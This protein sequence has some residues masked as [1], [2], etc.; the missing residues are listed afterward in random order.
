[1]ADLEATSVPSGKYSRPSDSIAEQDLRISCHIWLQRIYGPRLTHRSPFGALNP[2]PSFVVFY[3]P[4]PTASLS[5]SAPDNHLVFYKVKGQCCFGPSLRHGAISALSSSE[6]PRHRSEGSKPTSPGGCLG[7][8]TP[9]FHDRLPQPRILRREG[10]GPEARRP[11]RKALPSCRSALVTS[12]RPFRN[13]PS[14]E[15]RPLPIPQRD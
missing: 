8:A 10:H 7:L 9:H 3:N 2:T 1:M 5:G 12:K 13:E 14:E 11:G 4:K 15:G 6:M